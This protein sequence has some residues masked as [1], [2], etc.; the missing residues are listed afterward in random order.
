MKC[1]KCGGAGK[2]PVLNPITKKLMGD[3]PCDLCEGTGE[4]PG[5]PDFSLAMQ[6]LEE[7][8]TRLDRLI[9]LEEKKYDAS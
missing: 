2:I 6:K 4:L 3:K 8:I 9:I 5:E 1:E 7:I